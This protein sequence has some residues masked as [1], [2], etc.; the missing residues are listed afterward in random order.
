MEMTIREATTN[1]IP[2]I[3]KM[4][5]ESFP[6]TYEK[7]ITR[8][9][10]EFMMDWMYSPESLRKQM[11]EEHHTYLLACEDGRTLGYVSVQPV[12]E[13]LWHLHKIYVLP[14]WQKH[15]VGGFL[16]RHALDYVRR[17]SEGAARVELNVNRGN[18]ALGFYEHMGMKKLRSVDNAIGHGFYM[19]DYIMGIEL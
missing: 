7:L 1:D 2:L 4:A 13:G 6:K 9:Q 11:E 10:I 3:N 16:F 15:H 17:H 12:E 5:W 19:N 18:P 14:E 8:E